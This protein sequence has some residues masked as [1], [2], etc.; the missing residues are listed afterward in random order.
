MVSPNYIIEFEP[1]ITSD[2][3]TSDA[4]APVLLGPPESVPKIRTDKRVSVLS[5][6]ISSR[7]IP[8]INE[9]DRTSCE[10]GQSTTA[11]A[12]IVYDAASTVSKSIDRKN[13]D[14]AAFIERDS[15]SGWAEEWPA[16]AI[17]NWRLHS[18]HGVPHEYA[19]STSDELLRDGGG[20]GIQRITIDT[21]LEL[22]EKEKALGTGHILPCG[23]NSPRPEERGD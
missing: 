1:E 6:S 21:W 3:P 4:Q 23:G 12:E 7:D 18:V 13:S 15:D 11:L 16:S 2:A 5:S 8:G 14:D 9:S 22:I 10:R 20:M 19:W 17:V